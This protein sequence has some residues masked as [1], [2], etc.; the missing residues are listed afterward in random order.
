MSLKYDVYVCICSLVPFA[1]RIILIRVE[2]WFS[3]SVVETAL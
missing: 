2:L 1:E 3:P